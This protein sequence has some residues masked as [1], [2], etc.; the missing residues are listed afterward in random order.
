M[1]HRA[2]VRGLFQR[3]APSQ[4]IGGDYQFAP[5]S[6]KLCRAHNRAAIRRAA[7]AGKTESAPRNLF[8]RLR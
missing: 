4:F 3:I 6:F 8:C 1:N 2:D 7:L 5:E